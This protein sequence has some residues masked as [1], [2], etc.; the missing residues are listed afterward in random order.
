MAPLQAN[1]HFLYDSV[2]GAGLVVDPGG[3]AGEILSMVAAADVSLK[4]ILLTHGHFDHV[5]ATAEVGKATGAKVYGSQEAATVL[6]SPGD[7][8]LVPGIPPF[9][10]GQVDH[11]I[12]ENEEFSV[13]SI[14]VRTIA[15][16]GH[17][18][19]SITFNVAGALFCGDLIFRGSVG[20]TDL[21]GG[22]FDQLA[23]SIFGLMSDFTPD[24]VVYTG[25]GSST[26]LGYERENNPFL[27]GLD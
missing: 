17:T 15:T 18:P 13:D 9:P 21:P 3:D 25:H 24:T 27:A 10:A 1:C 23:E 22:S 2:T 7:H 12:G 11:I 19:G 20:R 5:G 26:T 8:I 14:G 16:P 6:A 4:A